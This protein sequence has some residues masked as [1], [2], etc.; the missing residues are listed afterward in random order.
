[1]P[2]WARLQ[3]PPASVGAGVGLVRLSWTWGQI[4]W[5]CVVAS[6]ELQHQT[7][8][9]QGEGW[10]FKLLFHSPSGHDSQGQDKGRS[11]ELSL[12]PLHGR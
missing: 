12:G 1:M 5:H 8:C 2:G 7:V 4:L 6:V 9:M 11:Q 10:V 3:N